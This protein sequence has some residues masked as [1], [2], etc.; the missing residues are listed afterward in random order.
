[1]NK[2]NGKQHK[3]GKERKRT[4]TNKKNEKNE[5]NEH[6]KGKSAVYENAK[7]NHAMDEHYQANRYRSGVC[8]SYVRYV[9]PSVRPSLCP[10]VHPF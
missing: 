5:Q 6:G 9:S 10:S 3:K 7:N 4:K 1:M 2:N 8:S